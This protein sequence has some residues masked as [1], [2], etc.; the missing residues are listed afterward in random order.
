MGDTFKKIKILLFLTGV[1]LAKVSNLIVI[2]KNINTL[3]VKYL[4]HKKWNNVTDPGPLSSHTTRTC[5][6]TK[7]NKTSLSIHQENGQQFYIYWEGKYE[8][9][10]DC[11]CG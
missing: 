4:T 1:N 10:D 9:G 6:L 3:I 11:K 8:G 5:T 7:R 2:C